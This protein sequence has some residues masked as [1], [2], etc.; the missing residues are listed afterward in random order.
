MFSYLRTLIDR[1]QAFNR[2]SGLVRRVLKNDMERFH[3]DGQGIIRS[4]LIIH[5]RK[6]QTSMFDTQDQPVTVRLL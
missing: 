6:M 2:V 1:W 3:I 4:W 5:T